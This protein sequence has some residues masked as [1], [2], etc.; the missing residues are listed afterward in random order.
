MSNAEF[1]ETL[2]PSKI[3]VSYQQILNNLLND[4]DIELKTHTVRPKNIAIL[5]LLAEMFDSYEMKGCAILLDTFVG[6]LD[7]YMVSWNRESRKEVINAISSVEKKQ[8]EGLDRFTTN[9]E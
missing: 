2:R 9:L 4:T 3:D 5:R 6:W 8:L 7:R 1:K